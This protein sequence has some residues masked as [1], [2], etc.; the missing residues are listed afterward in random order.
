MN[1]DLRVAITCLSVTFFFFFFFDLLL[2]IAIRA[3]RSNLL[4]IGSR[5]GSRNNV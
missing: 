1:W 5:D 4:K 3:L 2:K